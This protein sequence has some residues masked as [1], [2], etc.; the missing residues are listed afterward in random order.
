M[1]V[2]RWRDLVKQAETDD[3]YGLLV[4]HTGAAPREGTAGQ[5]QQVQHQQQQVQVGAYDKEVVQWLWRPF[6]AVAVQA[7]VGSFSQQGEEVGD[8]EDEGP[9]E[10][11]QATDGKH[12]HPPSYPSSL[13]PSPSPSQP[14]S[15]YG[16]A[17]L[18]QC[19]D[20]LLLLAKLTAA[21][22]LHHVFDTLLFLLCGF[23]GLLMSPP[24]RPSS[25]MPWDL[26]DEELDTLVAYTKKDI[27]LSLRVRDKASETQ[28][29]QPFFPSSKLSSR[30][31]LTTMPRLRSALD[32]ALLDPSS[33]PRSSSL[34]SFPP[35]SLPPSLP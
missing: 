7:F 17:F 27:A 33:L 11:G 24:S 1:T 21:H 5:Q 18:R 3:G 15:P 32:Y 12:S 34:A 25:D 6:L 13:P 22:S 14:L 2:D 19:L 29:S 23:T 9:G 8:G 26:Q 16:T 28:P 10:G 35:L 20:L 4:T 31:P 30:V